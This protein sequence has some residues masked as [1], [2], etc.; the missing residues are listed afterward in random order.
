MIP[1][2]TRV[3]GMNSVDMMEANAGGKQVHN[4]TST[5]M[6]QTWFVSHTGPMACSMRTRCG[7]PRS[8]PPANRSQNPAPK[9]APP[10]TA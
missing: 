4:T 8:G 5:K 10:S 1:T 9:S 7:R 3:R 2:A 6:S